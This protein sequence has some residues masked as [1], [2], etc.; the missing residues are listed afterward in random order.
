MTRPVVEL[1]VAVVVML[2]GAWLIGWWAVGIVLVAVGAVVAVDA[3]LRDDSGRQSKHQPSNEILE[4][5]RRAR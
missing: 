3:V 5:W 2:V 1:A 4:R